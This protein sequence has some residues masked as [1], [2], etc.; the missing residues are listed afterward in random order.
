M[1]TFSNPKAYFQSII[2]IASII[3]P[4]LIVYRRDLEILANEALQNEALGHIILT[5]FLSGILFYLKRDVVEALY[6][7]RRQLK[8]GLTR[9]MDEILGVSY[10]L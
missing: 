3:L 9:Y 5:P 6:A 8:R 2:S 1:E 4:I 10:F 7:L